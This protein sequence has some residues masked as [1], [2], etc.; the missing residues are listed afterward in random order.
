M[1]WEALGAA[2]LAAVLIFGGSARILRAT[3]RFPRF[4][5]ALRFI[6]GTAMLL[7]G[8]WLAFTLK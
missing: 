3:Q 1:A 7:M 6:L 2:G 4:S 5:M 8:L